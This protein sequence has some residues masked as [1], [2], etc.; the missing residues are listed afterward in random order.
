[1]LSNNKLFYLQR[2]HIVFK[3]AN[4]PIKEEYTLFV[5]KKI[6]RSFANFHLDIPPEP[7]NIFFNIKMSKMFL[8]SSS[9]EIL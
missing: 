3:N 8:V 6:F 5:R 1:M 4:M 9:F 7:G 2:S